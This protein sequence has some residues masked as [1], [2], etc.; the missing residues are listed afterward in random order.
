MTDLGDSG[1]VHSQE[2][3]E[4]VNLGIQKLQVCVAM[5]LAIFFLT[6]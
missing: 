6:V 1:E 2:G 4:Y 3:V 5:I